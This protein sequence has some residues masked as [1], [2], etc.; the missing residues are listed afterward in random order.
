MVKVFEVSGCFDFLTGWSKVTLTN[1]RGKKL[2]QAGEK[3]R[4]FPSMEDGEERWPCQ[5]KRGSPARWDRHGECMKTQTADLSK[6]SR[7]GK[8]AE[9][10]KEKGKDKQIV[11]LFFVQKQHVSRSPGPELLPNAESSLGTREMGK[12]DL[13][14]RTLVF[15]LIPGKSD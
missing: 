1:H 8:P 5:G 6:H 12:A 14:T 7:D 2:K 3:Q 10:S 9:T 13:Q 11:I 4:L 15:G